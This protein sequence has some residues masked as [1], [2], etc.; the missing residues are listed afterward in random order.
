MRCQLEDV[1]FHDALVCNGVLGLAS[2]SAEVLAQNTSLRSLDLRGNPLGAA[3]AEAFSDL[4]RGPDSRN[5]T[6]ETLS[7]VPIAQLRD[8]AVTEMDLSARGLADFEVPANSRLASPS[9][10]LELPS[11][12]HTL[13]NSFTRLKRQHQA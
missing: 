2:S 1:L 10:D 6:L 9:Q 4:L 11:L 12:A 3:A 7:S 5:T 8:N 13:R